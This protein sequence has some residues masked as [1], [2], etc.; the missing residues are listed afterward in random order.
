MPSDDADLGTRAAWLYYEASLTQ[1]EISSALRVPPAKVQRLI[2][3]AMRDG[4][5]RILIQGDMAGCVALER[6][7]SAAHGLDFCRVVPELPGRRP[8]SSLGRAAAGYLH[9]A[10]E[11]GTH[12][13]IGVGHGRT[14]AAMVD[15]LPLIERPD[16]TLV[17]VIGGVPRRVG[18]NPFD[19][20]HALAEKTNAAAWVMPVPFYANTEADR[21]VLLRQRGVAET[22]RLAADAG[23]FIMGVGEV[24]SRAFICQSA[25]IQPD[26]IADAQRQGAVAEAFGNFYDEAGI[27]ITTTLHDRVIAVDLEAMRGR[28]VLMV[29]GG[30]EK[31]AAIRAMLRSRLPTAL[32]TDEVTATALTNPTP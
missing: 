20:V 26:E 32:I 15:H 13:I 31:T 9:G 7:L 19:V 17:S 2:A 1:A 4:L 12:R 18:A 11:A 8:F 22:L 23:L 6:R 16:L 21:A 10:I 14:L 28:D 24:T 25:M 3:R 5:V 29:A 30:P 27:R